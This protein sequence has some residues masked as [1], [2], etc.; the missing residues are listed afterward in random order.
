MTDWTNQLYFG[1]NLSVL[2][3]HIPCESV[4]L[5]YLDPP[6]NSNATYNVL[7]KEQSGHDSD[8]QITA[9]DDTWRWTPGSELAFREVVTDGPDKLAKL[10]Q[11]MRDF[12]GQNDMM[13]YLTMMAQRLAEL[14]RVLKP[15]GSIY[16]H[17]DPTAS[18]YLK[19]LMDAVFGPAQYRNEITWQRTESHN[20]ANRYGNVADILLFYS[21]GAA[22]TWNSLYTLYG[23]SQLQRFRHEDDDGRRYKLENLTAPRPNS[24]SGKFNWRGTMPGTT[25]GWGYKLEQLEKWWEEGRI[26]TKKNGTPRL[27]GLKV[28]LDETEGKPL[29]NIWADISHASPTHLLSEWGTTLKSP[30]LFLNASS[31][32]AVVKATSSSIPSA[33]CGTAVAVAERLNRRWIGIDITHIAISLMTESIAR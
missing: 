25:R 16:L 32:L 29:Q 10:L 8:A 13:A 5:I 27:D 30:K 23:E 31:N 12:L 14:H 6:F 18:H 1:D 22:W 7:F 9:F 28:Y 19:L 24:N 4:D 2:R 33:S 26:R 21:K 17:C 3:N 20:T 15:T 11:A